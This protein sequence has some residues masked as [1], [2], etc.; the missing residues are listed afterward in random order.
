ML[1]LSILIEYLHRT[2]FNRRRIRNFMIE[3]FSV[4]QILSKLTMYFI[5]SLP[6][7]WWV[8]CSRETSAHCR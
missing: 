4:Q 6:T 1:T 7:I 2:S 5:Y 3:E 8:E